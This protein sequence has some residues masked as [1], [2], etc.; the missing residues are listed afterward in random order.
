MVLHDLEA[1]LGGFEWFLKIEEF[2]DVVIEYQI[3]MLQAATAIR[4]LVI[5]IR[6][7]YGL[8]LG[9]ESLSLEPRPLCVCLEFECRH[10]TANHALY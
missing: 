2:Y 5:G 10:W 4:P 9:N 1:F 7:L 6:W 8:S 3:D